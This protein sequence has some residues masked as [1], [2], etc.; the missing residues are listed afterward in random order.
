MY[1]RSSYQ[2]T[3]EGPTAVAHCRGIGAEFSDHGLVSGE[4][5]HGSA[6]TLRRLESLLPEV[7]E[8]C[9]P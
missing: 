7:F 8:T 9:I 6:M 5:M 4:G 2:R 3:F 1:L